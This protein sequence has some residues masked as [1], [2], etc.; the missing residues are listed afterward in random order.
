MQQYRFES[1]SAFHCFR[2]G[3]SKKSKLITVYMDD[4]SKRL[5][6]G[7]YG[8]LLSIYNIKS[9]TD[10][11]DIRAD[12][13]AR[14]LLQMVSH[15][16]KLSAKKLLLKSDRRSNTLSENALR[17]LISS[18]FLAEKLASRSEAYLEWSGALIGICKALEVEIIENI[19]WPLAQGCS[20]LDLTQDMLDKDVGTVAKFCH[21][22]NGRAPELGA[23]SH[24]LQTV[25]HSKVRRKSSNLISKFIDIISDWTGSQWILHPSNGLHHGI[26]LL[27]MNFRNK[28]AH[29]DDLYEHDY[30]KC[31]DLVIGPNGILWHL[32]MAIERHK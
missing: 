22:T 8:R 25:I 18:E 15:D 16:E 4:W 2:C 26:R 20:K 12:K 9:G 7:C 32:H 1:S 6:N 21:D 11:L 17:F 29:I 10:S 14:I 28:A 13:M 3:R 23:F 27:T 19:I 31:R 5:C 24:F 30:Q